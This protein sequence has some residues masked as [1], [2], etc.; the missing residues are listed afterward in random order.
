MDWAMDKFIFLFAMFFL[1]CW[2]I[3]IISGTAVSG[4]TYR[5]TTM[6]A[7]AIDDINN[8]IV[9]YI[10]KNGG[11][12]KDPVKRD[13]FEK[14]LINL[15][16]LDSADDTNCKYCVDIDVRVDPT[17]TNNGEIGRGTKYNITTNYRYKKA[18][19]DGVNMKYS[20]DQAIPRELVAKV[21]QYKNTGSMT[22][23]ISY[24]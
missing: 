22:G 9:S 2:I 7:S 11:Y 13:N 10:Q 18:I 20:Y 24:N 1:G 16:E 3:L 6:K 15:H 17:T 19:F 21:H 5:Q 23:S 4:M 14:A 8:T 12:I